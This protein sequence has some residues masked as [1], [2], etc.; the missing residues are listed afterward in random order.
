MMYVWILVL[1]F[2]QVAWSVE[3][4]QISRVSQ[5]F[6][7]IYLVDKDNQNPSTNHMLLVNR[8]GPFCSIHVTKDQ[9]DMIFFFF[10]RDLQDLTREDWVSSLNLSEISPCD[11]AEETSTYEIL[12]TLGGGPQYT[13]IG[14]NVAGFL[15]G[16]TVGLAAFFGLIWYGTGDKPRLFELFSNHNDGKDIEEIRHLLTESFGVVDPLDSS[17][18]NIIRRSN[19]LPPPAPSLVVSFG[20][21][22]C[23]V[24]LTFLEALWEKVLE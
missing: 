10:Q 24:S 17:M 6:H 5:I 8:N 20:F 14:G 3:G 13:S 19:G 11:P 4:N 9:R 7:S 23:S 22:V 12:V 16:C 18:A 1:I 2:S 21:G 15:V